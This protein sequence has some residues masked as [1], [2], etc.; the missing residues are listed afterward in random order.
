MLKLRPS[1]PLAKG[2]WNDANFRVWLMIGLYRSERNR[3]CMCSWLEITC[4]A[5]SGVKVAFVS[6]EVSGRSIEISYQRSSRWNKGLQLFEGEARIRSNLCMGGITH[7]FVGFSQYYTVHI[8]PFL[9]MM[10]NKNTW[11][12]IYIYINPEYHFSVRNNQTMPSSSAHI[13]TIL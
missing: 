3:G 11:L 8:W 10:I 6:T 13:S 1:W 7:T 12:C 9:V 4:L 2:A 5:Y